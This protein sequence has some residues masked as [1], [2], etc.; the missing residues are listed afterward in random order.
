M[1][2]TVARPASSTSMAPL[3]AFAVALAIVFAGFSLIQSYRHFN[4]ATAQYPWLRWAN[5]ERGFADYFRFVFATTDEVATELAPAAVTGIDAIPL[6][7]APDAHAADGASLIASLNE[8]NPACDRSMIVLSQCGEAAVAVR[9]Q[10]LER[11]LNAVE[12]GSD[13]W[14]D[15]KGTNLAFTQLMQ[16]AVQVCGL[17]PYR[18]ETALLVKPTDGYGKTGVSGWVSRAPGECAPVKFGKYRQLPQVFA[19]SRGADRASIALLRKDLGYAATWKDGEVA[20][21]GEGRAAERACAGSGAELEPS[22]C[23][24]FSDPVGFQAVEMKKGE[25]AAIVTWLIADPGLCSPACAWGSRGETL[26]LEAL[27][28]HARELATL[29]PLREAYRSMYGNQR[30]FI[31]GIG[32]E[33]ENGAYRAGIMITDAPSLSPLGTASPF[34]VGDVITELAGVPIFSIEDVGV[35]LARFVTTVGAD[36]TYRYQYWRYTPQQGALVKYEGSGTAHFDPTYWLSHGY[37]GAEVDA[38]MHGFLNAVSFGWYRSIG[39]AVKRVFAVVPSYTG[40]KIAA[41][42]EWMLM[43]QL[44]PNWYSWGAIPTYFFSP[45]RQLLG[46]FGVAVSASTIPPVCPIDRTGRRA[47]RY[48]NTTRCSAYTSERLT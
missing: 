27:Q 12:L 37:S 16:L 28:R 7:F 22:R 18:T 45:I 43:R 29:L 44:Y 6:T 13:Y 9:H 21:G 5:G 42:N 24:L 40:C 11:A 14:I 10:R 35:A 36:Q 46:V 41:A 2:T 4:A 17:T 48:S 47:P 15:R 26:P 30:P 34:R 32:V 1:A 31:L 23:G 3:M 19:H 39:C 20:W 33:D 38:L 8:I 25:G